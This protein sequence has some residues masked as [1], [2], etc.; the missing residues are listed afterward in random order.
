M[1]VE[2][3]VRNDMM[4]M[5]GTTIDDYHRTIRFI[6]EDK[7]SASAKHAAQRLWNVTNTISA[8]LEG[9]DLKLREDWNRE[10]KGFSFGVGDAIFAEGQVIEYT[11]KGLVKGETP[12][13]KKPIGIPPRK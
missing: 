8:K 1:I 13:G 9:D 6:Y 4:R 2:V 12:S 11:P 7:V 3:W 10:M 5:K